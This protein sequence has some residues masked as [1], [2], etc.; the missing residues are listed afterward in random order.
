MW[1]FRKS[2]PDRLLR[3]L[4]IIVSELRD[5]YR[6]EGFDQLGEL[7]RRLQH[8]VN[9]LA[10][11]LPRFARDVDVF[12]NEVRAVE[13]LCRTKD[14]ESFSIF[15]R[16]RF[17]IATDVLANL[18]K[19]LKQYFE[20]MDKHANEPS[21][22][23]KDRTEELLEKRLRLFLNVAESM[24]AGEPAPA[25]HAAPALPRGRTAAGDA[26]AQTNLEEEPPKKTAK[27]ILVN[28]RRLIERPECWQGG[29][30]RPG[31]YN[32]LA[33]VHAVMT[34]GNIS[35]F[36]SAY[37]SAMNAL[38]GAL[39]PGGADA[40]GAILVWE[41]APDRTHA[42]VLGFLDRAIGSIRGGDEGGKP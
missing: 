37:Q 10:S 6:P 24:S 21:P 5:L 13:E 26:P 25:R 31:A 35:S 34:L 8:M 28:A 39:P 12:S 38:K 14:V 16:T 20:L 2:L 7:K 1:P 30:P 11:V 19:P 42:E 23:Q 4:N 27:E 33:A 18:R 15:E 29:L 22:W 17:N 40:L 41:M 9:T 3:D 32:V 36:G